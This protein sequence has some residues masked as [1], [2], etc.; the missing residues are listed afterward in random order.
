MAKKKKAAKPKKVKNTKVTVTRK[1][2]AATTSIHL[3][4]LKVVVPKTNAPSTLFLSLAHASGDPVKARGHK[5][6]N[7]GND[8]ENNVAFEKL[9]S[10]PTAKDQSFEIRGLWVQD[11][12]NNTSDKGSGKL[13]IT[14]KST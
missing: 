2:K 11:Y 5:S 4:T 14:I 10:T 12:E 8:Y 13:T 7:H 1:P 3:G 6:P 9:F